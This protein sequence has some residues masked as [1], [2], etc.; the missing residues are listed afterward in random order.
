MVELFVEAGNGLVTSA[1]FVKDVHFWRTDVL[2]AG[3][4][5]CVRRLQAHLCS[6][7]QNPAL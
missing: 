6:G 2:P 5:Y 3:S 7:I 4:R 1:V